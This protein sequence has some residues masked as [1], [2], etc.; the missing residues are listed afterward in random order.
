MAR[1][2]VTV[3]ALAE[4]MG[5]HRQTVGRLVNSKQPLDIDDLVE[6]GMLLGIDPVTLIQQAR[7]A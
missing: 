7:T 1:K 5:L 4:F 3:T 2:S 6:I